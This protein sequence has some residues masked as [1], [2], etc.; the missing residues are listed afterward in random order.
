MGRFVK[1]QHFSWTS[2]LGPNE[3]FGSEDE[4]SFQAKAN[5]LEAR[6]S[7]N[8][9]QGN[10]ISNPFKSVTKTDKEYEIE[11]K[12]FLY[13][14]FLKLKA[15]NDCREEAIALIKELADEYPDADCAEN[16][17]LAK[18]ISVSMPVRKLVEYY[19]AECNKD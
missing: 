1:G 6:K 14:L 2:E 13:K 17:S 5:E 12:E 11:K 18:L 16:Y 7:Q 4:M 15:Y 3:R 9:T 19:T 10:Y 8:V